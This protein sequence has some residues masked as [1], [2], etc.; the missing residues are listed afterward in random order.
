M[1]EVNHPGRPPVSW[2]W[3]IPLALIVGVAPAVGRDVTAE[4]RESWGRWPA[5]L[6]GAGVAALVALAVYAVAALINRPRPPR[7]DAEPL[8]GPE[9]QE[10]APR[11]SEDS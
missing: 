11:N 4:L 5:M 6:A 2:R 10:R 9:S 7:P 3:V 1:A 8:Y